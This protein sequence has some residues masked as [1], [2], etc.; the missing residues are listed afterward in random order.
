MDIITTVT[1]RQFYIRFVSKGEG[2]GLNDCITHDRSEPLVEFYDYTYANLKPNF[3]PRGQFVSRYYASTLSKHV[4]PLNLCGHEPL[5]R[6]DEKAL[7][8]V[9]ENC[10]RVMGQPTM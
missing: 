8:P 7:Q 4:G 6:V 9:I 5:W 2:Y 3:G 1:G 10:K